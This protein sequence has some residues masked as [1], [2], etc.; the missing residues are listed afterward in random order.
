MNSEFISLGSVRLRR[1]TTT[2]SFNTDILGN[3]GM[4]LFMTFLMNQSC[5]YYD[6][7]ISETYFY[8]FFENLSSSNLIS[9][10]TCYLVSRSSLSISDLNNNLYLE[11]EFIIKKYFELGFVIKVFRKLDNTI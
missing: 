9:L 8:A 7:F 6:L 2:D 4:L 5:S 10:V 11:L 3:F 1:I